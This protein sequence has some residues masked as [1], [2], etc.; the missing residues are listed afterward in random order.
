MGQRFILMSPLRLHFLQDHRQLLRVER[1]DRYGRS[2][3]ILVILR[4]DDLQAISHRKMAESLSIHK[5]FEK[6]ASLERWL[7]Q[8]NHRGIENDRILENR[9]RRRR[10]LLYY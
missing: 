8:N 7:H 9:V 5:F 2:S 3:Q 1:T 4:V 6:P 10:L